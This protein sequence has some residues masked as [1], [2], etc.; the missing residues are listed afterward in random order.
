[1]GVILLLAFFLAYE[2]KPLLSPVPMIL[3]GLLLVGIV[4]TVFRLCSAEWVIHSIKEGTP[5]EDPCHSPPPPS[6]NFEE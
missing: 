5:S 6:D 3:G 4:S 1:V 2:H